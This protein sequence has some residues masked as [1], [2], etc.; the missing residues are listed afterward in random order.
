MTKQA[1]AKP[2]W[3]LRQR[4]LR[5]I[6]RT[7]RFRRATAARVAALD[8]ECSRDAPVASQ[9]SAECF[10]WEGYSEGMSKQLKNT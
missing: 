6:F 8:G 2:F 4:T 7:A 1:G 3:S 5:H 9:T 10:S